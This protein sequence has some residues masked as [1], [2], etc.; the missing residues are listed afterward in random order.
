MVFNSL[1]L[2]GLSEHA[3]LHVLYSNDIP[4]KQID[5][6]TFFDFEVP[7]YPSTQ[8]SKR[9]IELNDFGDFSSEEFVTVVVNVTEDIT[10]K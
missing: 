1:S 7:D 9:A 2:S 3:Y 5:G 10:G 6:E 8:F 4:F